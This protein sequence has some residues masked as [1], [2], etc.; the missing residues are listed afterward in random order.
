[1][2]L[3]FSIIINNIKTESTTSASLHYHHLHRHCCHERRAARN[4]WV[5]M[6]REVL[7]SVLMW[8]T[9]YPS[10]PFPSFPF[11]SFP[12][13]DPDPSSSTLPPNPL[14]LPLS[15]SLSPR[16]GPQTFMIFPARNVPVK[17]RLK[18]TKWNTR[19]D[20]SV[21]APSRALAFLAPPPHS[22]LLVFY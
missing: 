15:P 7:H 14:S 9:K 11:P 4:I 3:S 1:M 20:S 13:P 5:F 10:F 16:P 6:G 2:L 21:F 22:S 12:Y 18:R 17:L 8:R 19:P